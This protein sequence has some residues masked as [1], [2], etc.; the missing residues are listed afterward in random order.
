MLFIDHNSMSFMYGLTSDAQGYLKFNYKHTD[1]TSGGYDASRGIFT[2][3]A[4][5]LYYFRTDI[6]E[7]NEMC[8]AKESYL[9][10][11]EETLT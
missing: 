10:R 2:S 4:K 3:S 5:G 8:T 11:M 7:R 9:T 6:Y 1:E